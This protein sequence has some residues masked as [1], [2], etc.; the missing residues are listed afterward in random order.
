LYFE[1]YSGIDQETEAEFTKINANLSPEERLNAFNVNMTNGGKFIT[2]DAAAYQQEHGPGRR[3]LVAN[4]EAG[5]VAFHNPWMMH[6]ASMNMS[7][8]GSI[9]LSADVRYVEEGSN[10]DHRWNQAF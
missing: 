3:W 9:R 10:F 2:S 5:D 7:G 1:Q 4:Y 6:C 8:A